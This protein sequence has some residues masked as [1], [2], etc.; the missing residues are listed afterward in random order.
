MEQVNKL[1]EC[2]DT[3]QRKARKCRLTQRMKNDK[4]R[5]KCTDRKQEE[6]ETVAQEISST[7]QGEK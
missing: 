4:S 5:I 1:N 6:E 2:K 3:K 7:K